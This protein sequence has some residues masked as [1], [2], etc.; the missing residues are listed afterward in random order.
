MREFRYAGWRHDAVFALVLDAII[1]PPLILLWGE[2][3]L[4][5]GGALF[6]GTMTA[7]LGG[8]CYAVTDSVRKYRGMRLVIDEEAVSLVLPGPNSAWLNSGV[9]LPPGPWRVRFTD[10][11]T[12]ERTSRVWSSPKAGELE[13]LRI[14]D[15]DGNVHELSRPFEDQVGEMV[16]AI[17]EYV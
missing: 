7:L 6:V 12:V 11:R 16:A 13:T 8:L 17:K 15:R 3:P 9:D 10:V 4:T 5:P 1:L 2:V 14:V